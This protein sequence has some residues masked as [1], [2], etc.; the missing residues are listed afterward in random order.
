MYVTL[1]RK[2]QVDFKAESLMFLDLASRMKSLY[3]IS[4]QYSIK[5]RE[6]SHPR[7]QF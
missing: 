1:S 6:L 5:Q 2:K 3:S 7:F 4:E